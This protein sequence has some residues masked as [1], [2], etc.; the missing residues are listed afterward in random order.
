MNRFNTK[1][2]LDNQED[3]AL[4]FEDEL[5]DNTKFFKAVCKKMAADF[6]ESL[7]NQAHEID[8]ENDLQERQ[9]IIF[10]DEDILQ[11]FI[12]HVTDQEMDETKFYGTELLRQLQHDV[13]DKNGK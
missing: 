4:I 8:N 5:S 11:K 12:L 1:Y 13:V 7:K 2:Y 9:N 3:V 6:L 10:G